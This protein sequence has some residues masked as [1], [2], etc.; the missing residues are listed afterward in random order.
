MVAW[1]SGNQSW[2]GS[3]SSQRLRP[4][5]VVKALSSSPS[6][7]CPP[8]S[9]HSSA[10]AYSGVGSTSGTE[11]TPRA[12]GSGTSAGINEKRRDSATIAGEEVVKAQ[13]GALGV[14]T[15]AELLG[16]A[17]QEVEP[18]QRPWSPQHTVLKLF[19]PQ[20][21]L[22]RKRMVL[23]EDHVHRLKAHQTMRQSGR[24]WRM[25]PPEARVDV[26]VQQGGRHRGQIA[27]VAKFQ[28][29]FAGP[30]RHLGKCPHRRV[31]V[32]PHVNP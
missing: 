21:G 16:E 4:A 24:Q 30:L 11:R 15:D 8:L 27:A 17:V 7:G 14:V 18:I 20:H 3:Y 1:V 22:G 28:S 31:Q 5:S 13:V 9:R 25:D 12:W 32:A 6:S 2:A 29:Q 10:Q 19:G 26:T 23:A